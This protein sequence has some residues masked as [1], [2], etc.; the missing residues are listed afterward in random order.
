MGKTHCL[1]LTK[2]KGKKFEFRPR[3]VEHYPMFTKGEKASM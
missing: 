2:D 3:N 1:P